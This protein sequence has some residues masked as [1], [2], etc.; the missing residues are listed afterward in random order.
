MAATPLESAD[1]ITP[2]QAFAATSTS[3]SGGVVEQTA[4]AALQTADTDCRM[5]DARPDSANVMI[6][7][8]AFAAT[9]AS[10]SDV[11]V[12][13]INASALPATDTDCRMAEAPPDS[14]HV[15]TPVQAF[16][17]TTASAS[18]TG[19]DQT[20]AA[21]SERTDTDC[22][23]AAAPSEIAHVITQDQAFDATS[24]SANDAVP[25][26]TA[27]AASQTTESR[28]RNGIIFRFEPKPEQFS[29]LYLTDPT[30]ATAST[31]AGDY[32]LYVG[33][34]AINCAFLELLKQEQGLR[35]GKRSEDYMKLHHSLL[36]ASRASGTLVS[37]ADIPDGKHLLETLRLAASFGQV[38]KGD[39]HVSPYDLNGQGPSFQR[40]LCRSGNPQR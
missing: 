19:A 7:D 27:A 6:P 21:V 10:A 16:A 2:D 9:S 25:D 13:Q 23:V 20:A 14:A 18:D 35:C 26:Q 28:S 17:S 36:C 32:R 40:R 11:V 37:A 4:A 22:R 31:N 5:A 39:Q 24:A 12:E 33:G 38:R 30:H 29:P 15:I 34:G 3:T 8:Q 1:V